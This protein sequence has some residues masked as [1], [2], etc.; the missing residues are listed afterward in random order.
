MSLM[1]SFFFSFDSLS[2]E[3][4]ILIICLFLAVL[5]LCCCTGFSLVVESRACSLVA[6][7]GLLL[8]VAS[9]AAQ[10]GL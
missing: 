5:V 8:A 6:G 1:L 9:L 4:I 10:Q 7:H 3:S 2:I